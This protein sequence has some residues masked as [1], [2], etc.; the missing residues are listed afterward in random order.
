MDVGR[1]WRRGGLV[2]NVFHILSFS[3]YR[4]VSPDAVVWCGVADRMLKKRG[5]TKNVFHILL[6]LGLEGTKNALY[7]EVPQAASKALALAERPI[8]Y[9]RTYRRWIAPRLGPRLEANA[10]T[11]NSVNERWRRRLRRIKD[12]AKNLF[13]ILQFLGFE[14]QKNMSCTKVPLQVDATKGLSH[15]EAFQF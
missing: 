6:I 15:L 11:V 10:D 4:S 2:K 3:G 9:L 5:L 14:A 8:M 7:T 12:V 1:R 13:R